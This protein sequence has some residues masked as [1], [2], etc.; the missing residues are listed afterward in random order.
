MKTNT[1]LNAIAAAT[2]ISSAWIAAATLGMPLIGWAAL[3][4]PA[5][6]T[7]AALVSLAMNAGYDDLD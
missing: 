4:A 5:V 1:I 7:L 6:V 2:V 3:I